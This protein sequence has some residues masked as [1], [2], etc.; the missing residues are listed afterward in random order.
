MRIGE[1]AALAGVS[2]RTV[3]HYHHLGLLPEPERLANGYREYR[4]RDA[5]V[6]ARVRRLAEL[7]LSLDE[8]RDVL[9][10]ERGRDLRE[11]LAELDADLA[12]QQ[13][14]IGARRARLAALLADVELDADSVVSPELADVLRGLPRGS[15]FAGAD[16]GMLA[17]VE[18]AAGAGF[19]A[20]LRPLAEP[21]AAA[22]AGRIYA[23]LDEIVGAAAGDPRIPGIAEDLVNLL[24][25]GLAE[26][27]VAEGTGG[28]W[29]DEMSAAQGEVFRLVLKLLRERAC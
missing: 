29:L 3:R 26:L 12:R 28:G 5:L 8:I 24:P 1:L 18:T 23:R 21:D 6:L 13:E 22:R 7:G 17:L 10:D 14:A 15:R 2:T 11:V 4:L 16:R 20:M 25:K 19:A 9:A 27:M